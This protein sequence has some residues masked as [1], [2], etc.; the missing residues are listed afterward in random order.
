MAAWPLIQRSLQC[1]ATKKLGRGH[2]DRTK[3]IYTVCSYYEAKRQEYM[4]CLIIR[5]TD[6]Y[7]LPIYL[8]GQLSMEYQPSFQELFDPTVKPK[9]AFQDITFHIHQTGVQQLFFARLVTPG[10]YPVKSTQALC[11]ITK[12]WWDENIVLNFT[13][14]RGYAHPVNEIY[15]GLRSFS[16]V[17]GITDAAARF[18]A[19]IYQNHQNLR[20]AY[21]DCTWIKAIV[22]WTFQYDGFSQPSFNMDQSIRLYFYYRNLL[23]L[24]Q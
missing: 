4:I 22:F 24:F 5:T 20:V 13:L 2:T 7:D 14:Q 15:D 8:T 6:L 3:M 17:P 11:T 19:N 1:S 16:G 18:W 9:M 23:T 12:S 21:H 10:G